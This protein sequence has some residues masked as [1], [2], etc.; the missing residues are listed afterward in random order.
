MLVPVETKAGSLVVIHGEIIHASDA[1]K[2]ERSRHAYTWHC[3][4][5]AGTEY[6]KLNWLQPTESLPFPSVYEH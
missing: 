1:N 5:K 6:D 4:E 2:S 3:V